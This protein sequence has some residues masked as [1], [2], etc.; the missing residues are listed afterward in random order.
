[1]LQ[2]L[3][4]PEQ[5]K[6]L[7]I[8]YY[9][10]LL[11]VT[12]LMLTGAV[13][14]GA[15]ALIPVYMQVIGEMSVNEEK[16]EMLKENID[17]TKLLTDEVSRSS[18]MMALLEE[19]SSQV[20]L[21]TLLTE[22]LS[23]RP[24]GI[25]ITGFAFSATSKT[26]SILGIASTRDLVVPYAQTIETNKYFEKAPVPISNLAKNTNLDFQIAIV[27]AEQHKEQ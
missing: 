16:Y 21:S 1:M 10:R 2:N 9:V 6:E 19:K 11:T 25:T 15:T 3:L 8:E 12:A 24:H 26:L 14:I 27:L 4:Q 13:I 23:V 22:V 5:K 18:T 20:K 17:D 7:D